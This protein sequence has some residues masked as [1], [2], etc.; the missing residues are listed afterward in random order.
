MANGN[1]N[2]GGLGAWVRRMFGAPAPTLG[3][4]IAPGGITLARWQDGASTLSATAWRPL[5]AGAL[6]PTPLRENLVQMERMRDALSGC[7]EAL[8]LSAA[9]AQ[10]G[11]KGM[12]TAL[13]IPDQ[14][15]RLFVLDFDKLP[16]RTA[17][18]IELVRWRLKKSVPFEI[19]SSAVSFTAHRHD[20]GWQVISVVTPQTV[21]QQYEQLLASVGLSVS[22]ITLSSLAALPLLP[23]SDA[24]S[25]L[26][27]KLSPPWITTVIVQGEDLCLFRTGSLAGAGD[28][29]GSAQTILEA[30]YPAFAYFQDTFSRSLDHVYLCGLGDAAAGVVQAI[31]SEMHVPAQTLP[32]VS[33][34]ASSAGWS[35]GEAERYAAALAGLVRE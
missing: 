19:E 11:G 22:R 35:R 31:G 4:E 10:D 7:L 23:E 18:A 1:G 15:A 32:G 6:D 5:P 33:D 17:D 2:S 26:L 20:A 8:G 16:R 29:A 25:T 28:Q 9:K 21:V 14:A 34:A 13:V 24:S 3:C 27:V 30:I 12:D